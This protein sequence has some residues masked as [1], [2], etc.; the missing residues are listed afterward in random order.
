MRSF[1]KHKKIMASLVVADLLIVVTYLAWPQTPKPN[2][3]SVA[4]PT[5]NT[6]E[7]EFDK[8]QYPTDIASS[9]WVVVNKGR[10]LPSTYI[11]ANLTVPG[12][13]LRLSSSSGEMHVRAD[14]AMALETMTKSA[15]GQGIQ[16]MLASGYRSYSDQVSV[17]QNYAASQGAA[18][19][20]T[21]S[22]RAGHSEHQTGLAADL[23]PTS[24]K[25][26]LDQCFDATPEGQWLAANCYKYGFVIRYQKDTTNLTGYEYEPWHVRYIGT[27]L[28]AQLHKTGQTLE[29]FFDLPV[30]TD[31][32][33][34]SLQLKT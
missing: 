22:A 19:A 29:Q 15:S 30:Y 23:E 11:P 34:D 7:V 27:D 20:D 24:R 18:A 10:A 2:T 17:H 8:T 16:L 13:P 14:T 28:A 33:Q 31:Y 9:L 4:K 1:K 3:A 6:T 5:T 26:E 32:P 25:C 21:F 12:I